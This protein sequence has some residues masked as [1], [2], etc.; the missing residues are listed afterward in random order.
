M[1]AAPTRLQTERRMARLS[2]TDH[3]RFQGL[4]PGQHDEKTQH[5]AE[6]I[7]PDVMDVRDANACHGFLQISPGRHGIEEG[8]TRTQ[9]AG[10]PFYFRLRPMAKS[11][12]IYVTARASG[13]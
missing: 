1:T 7:F 8:G 2:A 4:P 5:H 10:P 12:L 9:R 3:T 13:R 11:D 6:I